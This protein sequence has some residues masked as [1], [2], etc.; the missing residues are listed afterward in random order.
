MSKTNSSFGSPATTDDPASVVREAETELA[1]EFDVVV[2]PGGFYRRHRFGECRED[3]T[4]GRRVLT[5][6]PLSASR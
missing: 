6:R 2:D 4:G 1:E 3:G 5:L